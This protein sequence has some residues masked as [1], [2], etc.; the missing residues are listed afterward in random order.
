MDSEQIQYISGALAARYNKFQRFLRPFEFRK[1]WRLEILV[2]VLVPVC[3]GIWCDLV[4]FDARAVEVVSGTYIDIYADVCCS[5]R[6]CKA[7]ENG[8]KIRW[9]RMGRGPARVAN[10]EPSSK[11]GNWLWE[12]MARNLFLHGLDREQN[13]TKF[14]TKLCATGTPNTPVRSST[15]LKTHVL[16]PS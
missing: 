12:L 3:T 2:P 6:P 5:A 8:L 14:F 4:R 11:A 15:P 1:P 16:R 7:V 10:C 13:F 9:V